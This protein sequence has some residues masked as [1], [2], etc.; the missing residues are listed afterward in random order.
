MH[1]PCSVSLSAITVRHAWS[2]SPSVWPITSTPKYYS[3]T[4][5]EEGSLFCP[6]LNLEK[7]EEERAVPVERGQETQ[8]LPEASLECETVGGG[9]RSAGQK[10]EMHSVGGFPGRRKTR[11]KKVTFRAWEPGGV[12]LAEETGEWVA[13]GGRPG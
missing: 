1:F 5:R 3:S 9:L 12:H 11:A 7:G 6:G 8:G 2:P 10:I 13:A 4:Y